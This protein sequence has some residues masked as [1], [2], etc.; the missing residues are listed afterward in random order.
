MKIGIIGTGYVGLVS[1]VMF[2]TESHDVLCIDSDVA[3]IEKLREGQCIIYEDELDTYLK[4]AISDGRINFSDNYSH[5][6]FCEAIFICV[7][8]PSNADG[9]ANLS[10]VYEAA[11]NAARNIDENVLIVIKSTVPPG[12]CNELSTYLNNKGYKHKV[13]S[14]PEFLREGSA[15]FDYNNP[16]RIV[17]G[18]SDESSFEILE[19]IYENKIRKNIPIVKAETTTSELIKYTSNSFLAIKLSFINE[20]A[21]LCEKIGADISKLSEGVGLDKRIGSLFLKAGPGY[22]GSCFP[23]D[24]SALSVLARQK[25]CASQILDAAIES[26]LSRFAL[27]S[28]KIIEATSEGKNISIL[29]VAFKAGTDDV[30]ESPSVEIIKLLIDSGYNISVYDPVALENFMQ[31]NFRNVTCAS[32]IIDCC[33]GADS[34]VILTEWEEFSEVDWAKIGEVMNRKVLIDF[35]KVTDEQ[36][37]VKAGFKY[38]TVGK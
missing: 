32:S 35:R 33:R 3:K 9:S 34:V 2:T 15:V 7:G 6:K 13:A 22:G 20:M 5:L 4:S 30:R 1:G 14:N 38:Y 18:A 27:M 10:F 28:D 25:D 17:I 11:E 37:V 16:D 31:Y 19:R 26:N 12:T 24:T 21:N 29:G 23:K 8:T 36:L